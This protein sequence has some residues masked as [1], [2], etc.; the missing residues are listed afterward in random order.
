[1][2]EPNSRL[3]ASSLSGSAAAPVTAPPTPAAPASAMPWPS[4]ARRLTSPLP[5]TKSCEGV[6]PRRSDLPM[7]SS[8]TRASLGALLVAMAPPCCASGLWLSRS[9]WRTG[10]ELVERKMKKKI[11]GLRRHGLRR[12]HADDDL[13]RRIATPM[14][15][16]RNHA[17]RVDQAAK[18][19][20]RERALRILLRQPDLLRCRAGR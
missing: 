2:I 10:A 16:L 1:M 4:R 19:A 7:R 11:S 20:P 13:C 8:L 15:R 5:A 9:C 18:P 12:V 6:R 17:P 3:H 14:R